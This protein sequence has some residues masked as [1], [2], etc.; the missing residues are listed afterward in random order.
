MN[1]SQKELFNLILFTSDS[2]INMNSLQ[3][4]KQIGE[5]PRIF[6]EFSSEIEEQIK[7]LDRK[8]ESC[9]EHGDHE[10]E[11]VLTSARNQLRETL[12][13]IRLLEKN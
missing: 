12:T 7:D 8:I 6:I 1:E 13:E 9:R 11:S 5:R 10:I 3:E 4:V 2:I